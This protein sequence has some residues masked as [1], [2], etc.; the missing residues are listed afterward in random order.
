[1]TKVLLLDFQLLVRYT[2]VKLASKLQNYSGHMGEIFRDMTAAAVPFRGY[3]KLKNNHKKYI[4]NTPSTVFGHPQTFASIVV[5]ANLPEINIGT[6]YCHQWFRDTILLTHS[7]ATTP[8]EHPPLFGLLSIQGWRSIKIRNSPIFNKN[9]S[10][11]FSKKQIFEST[12]ACR[13]TET[14]IFG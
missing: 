9:F 1:M 12:V 2:F 7:A 10:I 11:S 6:I 8:T 5:V 14:T 4:N 3:R 13:K